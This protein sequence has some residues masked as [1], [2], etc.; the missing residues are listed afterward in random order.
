LWVFKFFGGVKVNL[1][2]AFACSFCASDWACRG[3]ESLFLTG[4]VWLDSLSLDGLL[5]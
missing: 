3:G 5:S 4:G 1:C 2:L